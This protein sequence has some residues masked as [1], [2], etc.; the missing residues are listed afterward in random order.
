M[1]AV[2]RNDPNDYALTLW[3]QQHTAPGDVVFEATGRRWQGSV[4]TQPVIVNANVDY[5]D[6]GRIAARTGRQTPIGW[7]FHEI[8]WRGDTPANRTEFARR[9]DTVDAAYT[10]RDPD[11]V[12][13]AMQEFDA[14]YLVVGR[15]E[16]ANYPGL[17]PDY[18]SFLDTVFES[19]TYRVYAI[20]EYRRIPTS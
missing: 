7:Y 20:P 13:T 17:M 9:Q 15:V 10:S 11:R 2:A 6:A 1:A 12:I 18:A 8:Q 16:M 19:G 14:R 5:S 4:G 3:I